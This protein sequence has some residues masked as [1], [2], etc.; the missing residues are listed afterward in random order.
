MYQAI[1]LFEDET[2][3]PQPSGCKDLASRL[4]ELQDMLQQDSLAP[5]L[6][7][8]TPL[9]KCLDAWEPNANSRFCGEGSD[10]AK[11]RRSGHLSLEKTKRAAPCTPEAPCPKVGAQLLTEERVNLLHIHAYA[12]QSLQ[13]GI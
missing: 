7:C 8:N 12:A 2:F 11:N 1:V 13:R 6:C 5:G 10:T 9:L 4:G 3:D